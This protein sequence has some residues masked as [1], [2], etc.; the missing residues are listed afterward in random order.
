MKLSVAPGSQPCEHP[1]IMKMTHIKSVSILTVSLFAFWGCSDSSK[2]VDTHATKEELASGLASSQKNT[3]SQI[4]DVKRNTED[5]I[6]N[7]QK[8]A[9][10]QIANVQKKAE[11]EA[12]KLKSEVAAAL[13]KQRE[14]LLSEMNA[15]TSNLTSQMSGIKKQYE[16]LKGA[17]P[18]EVLKVVKEQIPDLETSVSKLK[19][20]ASKFNPSSIEELNAFKTKYQKEY[21]VAMSLMKKASELLE[22]SGVNIPKL[23]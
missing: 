9:E 11:E 3:E 18:E 21:D 16:S 5:Q 1:R 2:E 13:A 8:K 17:L 19:D 22:S 7:V 20:M 23:F 10:E 12:A 4:A 14:E 6:A 15:N